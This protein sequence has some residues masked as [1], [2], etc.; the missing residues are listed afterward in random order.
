MTP[1]KRKGGRPRLPEGQKKRQV[2]LYLSTEVLAVLEA[3]DVNPSHAIEKLVG[4][5]QGQPQL[6]PATGPSAVERLLVLLTQD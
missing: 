5:H 4:H 6:N 3:I 2:S 1:E